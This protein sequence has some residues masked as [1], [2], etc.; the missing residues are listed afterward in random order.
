MDQYR[1]REIDAGFE[2]VGQL[3]KAGRYS[4]ALPVV[5]VEPLCE[6]SAIVWVLSISTPQAL[7]VVQH[8]LSTASLGELHGRWV[9]M[10]MCERLGAYD[11]TPPSSTLSACQAHKWRLNA[12]KNK[13]LVF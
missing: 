11:E 5:G 4:E 2:Q 7:L 3:Y 6:L 10:A 1:Q 13:R 8:R 9:T 12:C